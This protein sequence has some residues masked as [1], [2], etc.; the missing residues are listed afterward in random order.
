MLSWLLARLTRFRFVLARRREDE[1]ARTEIEAHLALLADRFIG[2][3][4]SP[5]DAYIAA[6]RQFGNVGVTRQDI[7]DMNSV[8]WV[9]QVIQDLRYAARQLRC[10]PAS[11]AVVVATLGLG[12]GAPTRCRSTR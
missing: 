4:M 1:D 7:R 3:G 2:Q 8:R 6:R 11:A 10:S 9:E 12:I 5:E